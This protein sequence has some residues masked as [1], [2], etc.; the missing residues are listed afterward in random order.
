M[1]EAI[2][3]VRDVQARLEEIKRRQDFDDE[4][5]ALTDDLWAD[6]LGAIAEGRCSDPAAV[7]RAALLSE[8]F[9]FS[10]WYA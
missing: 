10:R 8:D 2:V 4:A 9:E 6:V 3:T 5:H 7:A 1:G